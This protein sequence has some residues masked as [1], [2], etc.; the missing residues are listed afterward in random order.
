MDNENPSIPDLDLNKQ[1]IDWNAKKRLNESNP[2]PQQ[3]KRKINNYGLV[4]Q[5]SIPIK[6]ESVEPSI[7]LPPHTEWF[8]INKIHQYE[9]DALPEFFNES[10]PR[11]SSKT[12]YIYQEYRD[13]MINTYQQNPSQYLT[14]TACRRNLAGDVCAIYRVYDFLEQVGLINYAVNLSIDGIF[15]NP[16]P[17]PLPN[18]YMLQ[19][20]TLEPVNK[21]KNEFE[22]PTDIKSEDSVNFVKWSEE[23]T[24]KL[25]EG[26]DIYGQDWSKISK[27][28]GNKTE[29][30]CI[31]HFTQLP[32][33]DNYTKT[34]FI[35]IQ[36][37]EDNNINNTILSLIQFLKQSVN[38][39]IAALLANSAIKYYNEVNQNENKM[40]I[41]DKNEDLNKF[42]KSVSTSAIGIASLKAY[43]LAEK[44]EREIEKLIQEIINDQINKLDKKLSHF[45]D[46]ERV[47]KIETEIIKKERERLLEEKIAFTEEKIKILSRE[48]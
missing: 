35:Q 3:K 6:P 37:K 41:D 28:I 27:H 31:L 32:I 34:D 9:K 7:Q 36:T 40:E 44:E 5:P 47:F 22:T 38:P 20:L 4:I 26:I 13:F 21:E 45:N 33:E 30:Q 29:D 25:L 1:N 24:L 16:P 2:F 15:P 8:D 14:F 19:L 43:F 17:I 11:T 39:K 10:A 48:T 12:P 18:E 46:L 23:D 42:K